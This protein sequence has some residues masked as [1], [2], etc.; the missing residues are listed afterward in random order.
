MGWLGR[1]LA[2]AVVLA[3]AP[4]SSAAGQAAGQPLV[5]A[6]RGGA[7]YAPENTMLAFANA[8]RLGVDV[9]EADA[10]LTADGHLVLI[11]DDR[12]ERTTDCEGV[13]SQTTLS[14]LRR[15]DAAYWFTPGQPVTQ[16]DRD[17][18]H[19]LRGRGVV[20][21]TAEELLT[22]VAGLGDDAPKVS[23]EAKTIPGESNF[24]PEGTRV[25]EA[26]VAAITEA[27]VLDLADVQSFWPPAIEAVKRTEPRLR[28]TFLTTTSF[29]QTATQNVAYVV[30]R[31]HD[32]AAPNF[33]A[34]DLSAGVV[35]AAQSA[36]KQVIPYTVDTSTDLTR[37]SDLGV[38]GIITNFPAC[39]LA[40]QGRRPAGSPLPAQ[41]RSSASVDGCPA[42]APLSTPTGDR[43]DLQTCRELRPRRWQPLSGAPGDD[44]VLRVVALQFK[45]DVRHVRDLRDLPHQDALPDGGARR[46]GH[47]RPGLPALV[48]YNEDIGLM[49][50]G[51]GSRGEAIRELATSP[52]RAPVGDD[53]PAPPGAAAALAAANAAYAQQVA[54]YQARFGPIDPRKQVFVAATDTFARAF[55]QTF[56]DIARDYGVWV[57]ATN[58]QADYEASTDPADIALFADPD[59]GEPSTRSTSPRPSG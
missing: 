47:L 49:T 59:L 52:L 45:Q 29:G 36:G 44:G 26:L 14:A 4:W 13:V 18:P 23:I 48:V 9:L 31:G 37:V 1:V 19:P 39:L 21:P 53:G 51:I 35:A 6:H 33:D 24:D 22:Y 27:G 2:I 3:L 12:L 42:E 17:A 10:Q 54:A 20:I 5:S 16:P 7:A 28:T 50:L 11:Y 25:A 32:I 38:D 46:P 8:V 57:V 43:P 34:P 56:S 58:N 40:L 15:C 41:I 55:S 30:S